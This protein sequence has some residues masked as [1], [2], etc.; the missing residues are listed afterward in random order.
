MGIYF[1][2][3]ALTADDIFLPEVDL[4]VMGVRYEAWSL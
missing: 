4:E 1:P 3:R 2:S